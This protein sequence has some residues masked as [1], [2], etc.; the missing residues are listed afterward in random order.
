MKYDPLVK[1]SPKLWLRMEE[2]ERV[3]LVRD[4]HSRA[5]VESPNER[6]HALVHAV[7]ENQATMGDEIPVKEALE[8]LMN[9]GLDRHEAIHAVGSVLIGHIWE[10]L[11]G[12]G[13]KSLDPN[14]PYFDE[15]RALTT[16]KWMDEYADAED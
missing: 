9:E 13:T 5:G 2:M 15:I 12:G 6:L 1:P 14:A 11:G 8:R 3:E 10:L 7:V 4:Y 16:Q